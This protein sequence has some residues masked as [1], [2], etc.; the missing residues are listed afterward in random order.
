MTGGTSLFNQIEVTGTSIFDTKN[1]GSVGIGTTMTGAAAGTALAVM[2]GNVGIGSTAPGTKFDVQGT[3]RNLGEIVNGNVG[4]GTTAPGG[5]L[6]VGSGSICLGHNCQSN[7]PSLGNYW[8]NNAGA[9]IGIST[10]YA[11]GIGTTFVGGTGEAAFSV[12][13]GNVGIGTWIP[14]QTLQVSGNIGIGTSLASGIASLQY[15]G[16]AFN[17]AFAGNPAR[18]TQFKAGASGNVIEAYGSS[19]NSLTL[20]IGGTYNIVVGDS[21]GAT[22]TNEISLNGGNNGNVGIGTYTPTGFEVEG[23]NVGIG[24]AFT[25]SAGLTVMNGNVGIGTWVPSVAFQVNNTANSPF[26]VT[27]VG[28]VGIGTTASKGA[29]SVLSGNVGIGTWM[30]QALL[31]LST[32]GGNPA[33][34]AGTAP[35][36]AYIQN[37]LEVDGTAYLVNA[38]IGSLT[39]STGLTMTG[40]TSLFNQIEVTGT[41][42][43]N[44]KNG[45]RVGIGTTMTGSSAGTALAVMNGNVGIGTTTPQ[46]GLVVTNGNVGIGTWVPTSL[47]SIVGNDNT[48]NGVDEIIQNT[49]SGANAY[50]SVQV[51]S[52]VSNFFFQSFSSSAAISKYGLTLNSWSEFGSSGGNGIVL[53]TRNSAPLVFGTSNSERM[54]IDAGGN[55]GIGTTVP[56]KIFSV[57][58]DSYHNGNIGIGTT[59]TNAGAALSVMNGN[60]GIGTWKPQA[61]LDV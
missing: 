12:M 19:Q 49:S 37:N 11:V 9:N 60:V 17:L 29:L 45:G 23:L 41:S 42:I 22:A 40:G 36:S 5:A 39:L 56:A 61:L 3:V 10:T 58:G 13:N 2:N 15:N 26:A 8:I 21:T 57:T 28:N 31:D 38:T 35:Q 7:W 33:F 25:Q 6:D 18:Y 1:G 43:F 55:V 16:T 4:I 53:G 34:L 20:G 47:L 50:A 32:G 48:G 27:T 59:I 51:L 52:D 44:T 14:N 30:P 24:T 54:R 46:G